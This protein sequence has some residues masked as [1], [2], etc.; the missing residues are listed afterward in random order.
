MKVY[1]GKLQARGYKIAIVLSRFNQFISGRLLDGALE[2]LD[3]LGVEEDNIE[4][5]K[6]PGAFEVP[7][8]AKKLAAKKQVDGLICLG[9]LIRGDTPHF[10]YLSSEVT[11]GL[12]QVAIEEGLPI[13]FGILTVE[14]VEQAIERAG[15]KAGNKGY[16]AALAIVETI[17]LLKQAKLG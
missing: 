15:T 13:S 6:V 1:E 16:E 8:L 9:A 12:S 2:A 11:K 14:T 7:L 4:V 5:Y 10:D 3:K 17:N